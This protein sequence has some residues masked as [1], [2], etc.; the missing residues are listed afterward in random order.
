[1][2]VGIIS[3]THGCVPAWEQALAGPLAGVDL[4]VHAGDV[5]YHGP[6]NP[7][8][9]GYDPPTLAEKINACPVPVIIARGNCDAEVDQVLVDW[10]LQAP[11]AFL[12]LDDIR[13]MVQHQVANEAEMQVLARKYRV[14][15]FIYGHTHVAVCRQLD[16][17]TCLNPGSPTLPKDE[18][19]TP[20]VAVLNGRELELVDLNSGICL[21]KTSVASG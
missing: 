18:K 13:I 8:V 7:L 12:Q 9:P 17:L 15:L 1:M 3:D 10:P 4:I 2:K 14:N 16:D 19:K 20:T 11:Y 6:R 21:A 5:L